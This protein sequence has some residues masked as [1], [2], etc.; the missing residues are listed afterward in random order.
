MRKLLAAGIV[1]LLFCAAAPGVSQAR[2]LPDVKRLS[3]EI[4][5]GERD[6]SLTKA[7]AR[8]LR[9]K[10]I[11]LEVDDARDMGYHVKDPKARGAPPPAV[12]LVVW[13]GAL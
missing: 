5:R 3:A 7:E 6:G 8:E 10:L 2:R 9:E 1:G 11:A 12:T 4:D 13:A